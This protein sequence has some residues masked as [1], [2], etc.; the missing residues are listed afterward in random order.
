[1]LAERVRR[2]Q[3]PPVEQ[4]LPKEP[5]VVVP[6]E[7]IGR[8]GGSWTR[9]MT[10][11]SDIHCFTRIT[12]DQLLRFAPN[13][14]EGVWPNLVKSWAFRDDYRVLS[15]TLRKGLKWSDGHPF[16]VDDIVFW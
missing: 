2:K 15:L 13:P 8:Y 6:L 9:L 14:Q 1:M 11:T 7:Q 5:L 10:S 3:L 12:D 4:R 16:T